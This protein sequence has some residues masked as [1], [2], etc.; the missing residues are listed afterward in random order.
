MNEKR[1]IA[2]G[3]F[4]GV[5]LG[6]AALLKT[7][8]KRAEE[9]GAK[10]C[11][12]TFDSHPDELVSGTRVELLNSPAD[13]EYIARR[14]FGIEEVLT[15][16]FDEATMRMPWRDFVDGVLRDY[17]AVHFVVGDD[18]RFG[19]RGEGTAEKLREL[20]RE[21]GCGCDVIPK[22]SLDGVIVSSTYV[23]TLVAAGDVEAANRF[24]GHPHLLTGPVLHGFHLGHSLGT[25]TIN[26]RFEPGVLVPRHGVYAAKVR[27][28]GE[29]GCWTAVTNIGVRPTVS[30]GNAVSVESWLMDFDRDVYGRLAVCELYGFLRPERKFES[31]E[32]LSEQIHR[33]GAHAEEFFKGLRTEKQN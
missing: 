5:H 16:H 19:Y 17:G 18:F 8:R 25:P 26:Q 4:D 23:R 7:A 6:H 12:L 28:P 27:F 13:R 2:L 20:G 1:V 31:V 24:L 21:K 14:W 3:F 22:V 32:A 15:I 9:L 10:P 11:L 29:E 33:D 30:G